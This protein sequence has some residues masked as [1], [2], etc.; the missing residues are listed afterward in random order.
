M[1]RTDIFVIDYNDNRIGTFLNY[2]EAEL[3]VLSCLQTKLMIDYATI[4]TFKSNSCYYTDSKIIKLNEQLV[5]EKKERKDQPNIVVDSPFE[6][7]STTDTTDTTDTIDTI[8]TTDTTINDTTINDYNNDNLPSLK[9]HDI[10]S[11]KDKMIEYEKKQREIKQKIAQDKIKLRHKINMLKFQRDKID[12]SKNVYENDLRLFGI[13]SQELKDTKGFII[14]EIFQKKFELFKK[15]S[16]E[17]R[18]SWDNFVN[19]F[20]H[21]NY[22]NQH[23]EI[24]GF[25]KIFESLKEGTDSDTN[26][27]SDTETNTNTNINSKS[28]LHNEKFSG[29]ISEEFEI[30]LDSDS[31]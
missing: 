1:N 12:E 8:D 30:D 28:N 22:Y 31:E 7:S 15:L 21:E 25:E 26:S 14:P 29:D 19:E 5:S 4:L 24:N 27:D 9:I 11:V 13:F 10:D 3:F 23:F 6:S 18:L 20:Q 17:G 16:S 2:E